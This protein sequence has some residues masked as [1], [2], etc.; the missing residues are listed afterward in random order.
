MKKSVLLVLGLGFIN[1]ILIVL[2]YRFELPIF[3]Q[4]TSRDAYFV[5]LVILF[6]INLLIPYL[7]RYQCKKDDMYMAVKE[8]VNAKTFLCNVFI[9][10]LLQYIIYIVDEAGAYYIL[11]ITSLLLLYDLCICFVFTPFKVNHEYKKLLLFYCIS[12]LI[13]DIIIIL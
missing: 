6:F 13:A 3:A 2:F 8:R 11:L 1:M 10:L 7:I 12:F 9:L 4:L 5:K